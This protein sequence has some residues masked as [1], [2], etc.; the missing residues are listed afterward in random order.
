MEQLDLTIRTWG[1]KRRGAGRPPGPGRRSV[2]H[3]RRTP[4]V[5]R[6]PAHVTL[7]AVSGLPSLRDERTFAAIQRALGRAT[8]AKFRVFEYS[9]Q[10]DH[11]HLL[12]EA[13]GPTRFE[14]GMRGLTIR[15]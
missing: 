10:A 9:V 7:C 2:P 6:Y 11:V 13:D 8:T 14:R 3:R 15:I 4:H 1:G 12:V 5:A